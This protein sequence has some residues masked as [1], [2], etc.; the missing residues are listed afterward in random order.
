MSGAKGAGALGREGLDRRPRRRLCHGLGQTKF[1]LVA[2]DRK[3]QFVHSGQWDPV[4][5]S[6]VGMVMCLF[7]GKATGGGDVP[8]AYEHPADLGSRE[9]WSQAKPGCHL[10]YSRCPGPV[11]LI[12]A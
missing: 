11:S 9:N 1:G 7:E 10:K 2:T 12:L 8:A 6:I 5:I 4:Y 3:E